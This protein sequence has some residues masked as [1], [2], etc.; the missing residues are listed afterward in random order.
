L[1]GLLLVFGL[2]LDY[3]LFFSRDE[4]AKERD[5]THHSLLACAAS[6][7]LAFG[8]LGGSSIPLLK[9]LGITVAIGSAA[10]F[11]LAWVGS[12]RRRMLIQ[13]AA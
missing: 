5:C 7:V 8:I 9:N 13:A 3:A 4:S 10:S 1:I 2:G 6:T 12:R 11:L